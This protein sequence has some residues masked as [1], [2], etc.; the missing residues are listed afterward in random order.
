MF[1]DSRSL[2]RRAKVI[3]LV[4]F[5]W[6]FVIYSA[7]DDFSRLISFMRV[8]TNNFAK[9]ALEIFVQGITTYG[10]P[11]RVRADKGSEFNHVNNFMNRINGE[12]RGSFIQ[13]RSVHNQ[14]IE[15]LWRDVHEKVVVKYE[16]IFDHMEQVNFC[17]LLHMICRFLLEFRSSKHCLSVEIFLIFFQH[18][19][20]ICH[21]LLQPVRL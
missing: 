14:R 15:R 18:C 10:I 1:A 6:N 7:N 12:N 16:H 4:L 3:Y 2:Y 11:S 20:I 5:R 13:G 9:T 8:S 21:K 17:F 19:T